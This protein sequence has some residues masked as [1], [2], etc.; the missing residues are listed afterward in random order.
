[1][2]KI[3]IKGAETPEELDIAKD[4]MARV[5]FSDYYTGMRWLDV[6]DDGWPEYK[7]EHNRMLFADGVLAAA[8]RLFTYTARIGEARLKMGG[9]GCVTTAG[10]MRQRGYA[11]MLMGD[12]MRYLHAHGY[13]V[14]ALF[15]IADFY[16]RWGFASA[17]PEYA[18][19]I[20]VRE[21]AAVSSP[22][23][24]LRAMKPG[25]I[26][27][28]QR[29]HTRNDS[30]TACSIIRLGRHIS[31]RWDKWRTARI[32]TDD[33]GRVIAYFI[34]QAQSG[35]YVVE[36][37][38]VLDYGWCP[39]L[40]NACMTSAKNECAARIRFT[41]PPSHPVVHY[42]LHYKSDHEMHVSRD[43]NGM[44][45]VVNIE[46][47]LECMIP[48]W[49]SRLATAADLC[50]EI[51]LIVERKPYRIRVHHGAVDVA[52]TAGLNKVSLSRAEL[53]QL[54]A[55]ARH[56]EEMLAVKR[57]VVNTAG[58][59]LLTTIFPKRTPYIWHIDRF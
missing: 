5:H 10:P 46:E 19:V 6:G 52:A 39:A 55:G 1:M 7:R 40:L 59:L 49:E 57:R 11:A 20:E 25:D 8:L 30:E 14:S 50:A 51:T 4:L 13:H 12:S 45:A 37:A 3:I 33:K 54:I 58:V 43:S 23:F 18:S 2:S 27:A 32:V 22:P 47:T 21:A 35:E 34:G 36:D 17:L 48:E 41:V 42:L 24:R 38:G 16:H 53:A 31:C 56:S 29:I 26:P 15:G 44:L 9:F 28:V